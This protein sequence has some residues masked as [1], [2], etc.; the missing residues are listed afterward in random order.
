MSAA[1]PSPQWTPAPELTPL[2]RRAKRH[3]RNF[4]NATGA[5][6]LILLHKEFPSGRHRDFIRTLQGLSA[7]TGAE[8]RRSHANVAE[9]WKKTGDNFADSQEVTREL[10]WLD[11]WQF[12]KKTLLFGVSRGGG[13]QHSATRYV[14]HL[15]AAAVW[16]ET[17]AQQDKELW[18]QN[19]TAAMQKYVAEA[20]EMLPECNKEPPP[21]E[22]KTKDTRAQISN[23]KRHAM[24]RIRTNFK[25]IHETGEGSETPSEHALRVAAEM[26][27]QAYLTETG[28]RVSVE[29]TVSDTDIYADDAWFKSKAEHSTEQPAEDV[30]GI[31]DDTP[32]ESEPV[33]NLEDT[34]QAARKFTE[35]GIP[36][37]PAHDVTTGKC[38]CFNGASCESPGKHP[39][40]KGWQDIATTDPAQVAAWK[41]SFPNANYAAATGKAAGVIVLDVDPEKGGGESLGKLIDLHGPFDETLTTLTGG[42]GFHAFFKYPDGIEIKNSTSKIA[43]GLDVRGDGGLVIIPPSLH[44]SG[45]RYQL[46]DGPIADAPKWLIDLLVS[47]PDATRPPK[48]TDFKTRQPIPD[49]IPDGQRN[50]TLFK[51]V[52]CAA[53]ARGG[54]LD[55][56]RSALYVA[57]SKCEKSFEISDDVLESMAQRVV[58][59]YAAGKRAS[60][61]IESEVVQ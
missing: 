58:E 20:A 50:E 46:I 6:S 42:G 21:F 11:D 7:L 2:E 30:R 4:R 19:P 43:P 33:E 34:E 24:Q 16:L 40:S 29:I 25:L 3:R 15:S 44:A 51:R 38:S 32:D 49:F 57:R 14:N 61:V 59:T 48:V 35:K 8:F 52:A 18:K 36:V 60:N 37:F 56:I 5:T 13:E 28:K 41:R 45:R 54:G 53:R 23:N 12:K 10:N 39:R 26:I 1:Q 9:H 47:P 31:N 55:E 27:K 22:P 17:R